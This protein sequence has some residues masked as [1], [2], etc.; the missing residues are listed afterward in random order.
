MTTRMALIM[1]CTC[2]LVSNPVVADYATLA[3][4]SSLPQLK[5]GTT[6]GLASSYDRAGSNNDFS[7]YDN[8]SG[9][10]LDPCPATVRTLTGPGEIT[11]FWMPHLTAGRA[12]QV[13][14]FFDGETTPRIDTT[15]SVLLNGSYAYMN[16]PLVTTVAGG[17][18]CYEPI[19]FQ[20][21]LR[22]ETYNLD[23]PN[24]A[25][26]WSS[27]RHYYQY[28]YHLFSS[29]GPSA[30][31]TGSLTSQQQQDRSQ[32]NTMLTNVGS[33]PAGSSSTATVLNLSGLAVSANTS[34][35]LAQITGSGAVRKLA[36]K[37]NNPTDAE[38]ERLRLR[39]RY[40]NSSANAVDVPV[41]HFFGAGYGRAAYQ[42]LPLGAD[43][44]T[45]YYCYWPMP[46]RIGIVIELYNATAATI[47]VD[48]TTVEYETRTVGY[49]EAYLHANFSVET[50][51][52]GQ[53][54]H[55]LLDV[56]GKGHYVGNL[57]WLAKQNG[58]TSYVL[59]G[60]DVI[61][62]DGQ[63]LPGTGLEDAYNG[64][65]YYNWVAAQTNEPEGAKP[66][67]ATRPYSGLLQMNPLLNTSGAFTGV[68]R[69]DQYRWHI[70]DYVPFTN[71]L[72][73]KLE[74]INGYAGVTYGSTAFYYL[75]V[76]FAGDANEDGKVNFSDYLTM[77]QNFGA[78]GA[79]GTMWSLGD[80]TGD[81]NVDFSDYLV[82]S[83]NFGT[84]GTSDG[85][86]TTV[87]SPSTSQITD[88]TV[89]CLPMS[90][91]VLALALGG[92]ALLGNHA[93]SSLRR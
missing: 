64:G 7:Q 45:G 11:R 52:G 17:Q 51:I 90:V 5:T 9:L 14:M 56:H 66:T 72:N 80:F 53:Q 33:N 84:G 67:S 40:D 25:N 39:I 46:Y 24:N 2:F 87:K 28:S 22:I 29:G 32:V 30:S 71:S 63:T 92:S 23:L 81:G 57:L 55:Q 19:A 88:S 76:P 82:L 77:S 42:S 26:D 20:N 70:P 61:T 8:P 54:Y 34:I 79:A 83:T 85:A 12:F 65:Y 15:S 62:A 44:N 18:V 68:I 74:N 13:K 78:V 48:T 75:F 60:D 69:V 47:N 41:A 6:A 73:V 86:E 58:I 43:P 35:P 21:S 93:E 38:L 16:G 4:W 91:M 89:P 3:D 50:T 59:E 1:L 27:N 37:M 10:Q 49:D 31:Y 36:I